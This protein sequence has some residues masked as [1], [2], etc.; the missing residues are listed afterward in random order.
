LGSIEDEAA[1][2]ALK[3][4]TSDPDNE[5]R[6]A[7]AEALSD[8]GG[9]DAIQALMGLLKDQDPEIRRIAAEALGSKR[10]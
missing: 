2:P 1:V 7:A 3:R 9:P 4:A 8:I 10:H 5:V 6:R